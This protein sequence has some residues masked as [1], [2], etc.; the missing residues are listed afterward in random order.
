L[1]QGLGLLP[2]PE[3]VSELPQVRAWLPEPPQVRAE[4]QVPELER[5]P[6]EVPPF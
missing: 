5:P 6:V 1:E 3:R 2:E 4:P